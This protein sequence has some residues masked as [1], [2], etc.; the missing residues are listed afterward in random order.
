M[1]RATRATA[2]SRC[3]S[4]RSDDFLHSPPSIFFACRIG[5]PPVIDNRVIHRRLLPPSPNHCTL[6]EQC[7]AI[8]TTNVVN[9][10]R[11]GPLNARL[12]ETRTT[13]S[14]PIGQIGQ[15]TRA[16]LLKQPTLTRGETS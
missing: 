16:A 14:S 6:N 2:R 13:A 9:A 11:R 7:L 5:K 12:I 1:A 4:F 10:D 15:S 3:P 8:F